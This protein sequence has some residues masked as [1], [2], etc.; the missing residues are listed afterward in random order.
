MIKAKNLTNYKI[1]ERKMIMLCLMSAF[2]LLLAGC[3][4]AKKEQ[5]LTTEPTIGN[6]ADTTGTEPTA[7]TNTNLGESSFYKDRAKLSLSP[8]TLTEEPLKLFLNMSMASLIEAYGEPLS[9][10][11]DDGHY[12]FEYLD[13]YCYF[14]GPNYSDVEMMNQDEMIAFAFQFKL[15]YSLFDLAYGQSKSEIDYDE[16][17]NVKIVPPF[18]I[19]LIWNRQNLL[20]GIIVSEDIIE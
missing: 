16:E 4:S 11:Y 9:K 8:Y 12:V 1:K 2:I 17:T 19:E 13:F 7:S 15:S 3:A 6:I 20:A 10:F 14:D 5:T 18:K